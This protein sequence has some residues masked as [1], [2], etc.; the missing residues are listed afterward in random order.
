M[1][2]SRAQRRCRW[3]SRARP[4]CQLTLLLQSGQGGRRP[5]AAR[6]EFRGPPVDA[7]RSARPGTPSLSVDDSARGPHD[8]ARRGSSTRAWPR[9]P[10]SIRPH[11]AR[12]RAGAEARH[13]PREHDRRP[14]SSR[15][16]RSSASP[17]APRGSYRRAPRR[18]RSAVA[19]HS[20]SPAAGARTVALTRASARVSSARWIFERGVRTPVI[21]VV[22]V[23]DRR[24]CTSPPRPS[25]KK[26]STGPRARCRAASRRPSMSSQV[27]MGR[28][29][30]RGCSSL[31][32]E[33]SAARRASPPPGSKPTAAILCRGHD[34]SGGSR[35]TVRLQ[36]ARVDGRAR[37]ERREAPADPIKSRG[38][39]ARP[40]TAWPSAARSSRPCRVY[41]PVSARAPP[42]PCSRAASPSPDVCVLPGGRSPVADRPFRGPSTSPTGSRRRAAECSSPANRAGPRTRSRASRCTGHPRASATP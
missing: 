15:E 12:R 6:V 33:L 31:P 14:G 7:S 35:G 19:C 32:T 38:T 13:A 24:R 42:L 34:R 5:R 4:G 26:P 3:L 27:V 17:G 23:P 18:T 2:Q 22:V 37:R 30:Q 29:V 8:S 36:A 20:G 39:A 16:C 21:A 11:H 10:R 9:G 28:A 1:R 41:T 40:A 25:R